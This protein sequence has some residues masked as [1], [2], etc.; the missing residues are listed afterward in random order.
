VGFVVSKAVGKSV[1]RSRTVRVLRHIVAAELGC[2]PGDIDLVVRAQPAITG[3]T[4][5]RVQEEL[6]RQLHHALSRVRPPQ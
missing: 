3:A 5:M 1:V 2:V 6:R 4:T